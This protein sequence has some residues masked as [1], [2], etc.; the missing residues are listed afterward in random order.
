MIAMLAN[1]YF[2]RS[3]IDCGA[4]LYGVFMVAVSANR[5]YVSCSCGGVCVVRRER[6]D[7]LEVSLEKLKVIK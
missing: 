2:M 4:R 6:R 3:I 1:C 7:G 5:Q